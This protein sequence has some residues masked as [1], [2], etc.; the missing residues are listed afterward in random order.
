MSDWE[1][2]W[3]ENENDRAAELAFELDE[4]DDPRDINEEDKW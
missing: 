2:D 1:A 4:Q 3:A